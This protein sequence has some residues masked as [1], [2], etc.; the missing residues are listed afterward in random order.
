MRG[1][2]LW[3]WEKKVECLI[4]CTLKEK[5]K[6]PF[7]M[8]SRL[9][10]FAKVCLF[11]IGVILLIIKLKLKKSHNDFKETKE[12][13]TKRQKDRKTRTEGNKDRVTTKQSKCRD[14]RKHCIMLLLS[15]LS[16]KICSKSLAY[17]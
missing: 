4:R 14:L 12:R 1:V 7:K 9:R 6:R 15:N 10:N 11:Y 13:K 2:N 3:G 17:T 5:T 8:V 16:Q